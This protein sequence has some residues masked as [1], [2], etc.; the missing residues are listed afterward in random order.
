[1][2]QMRTS[3]FVV[4]LPVVRAVIS[5]LTAIETAPTGAVSLF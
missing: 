1:M 5:T 2:N 4:R 3:W